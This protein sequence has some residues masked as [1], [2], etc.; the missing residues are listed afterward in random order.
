M[1]ISHWKRS[2]HLPFVQV[3][4]S[5]HAFHRSSFDIVVNVVEDRWRSPLHLEVLERREG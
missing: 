5:C 1:V 2:S 4:R 3:C